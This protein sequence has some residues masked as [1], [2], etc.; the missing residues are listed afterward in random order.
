EHRAHRGVGQLALELGDG[1]HLPFRLCDAPR[2]LV[3]NPARPGVESGTPTG[4]PRHTLDDLELAPA[5]ALRQ[6]GV[7]HGGWRW[8]VC[9]AGAAG[10]V[11][12]GMGP[13]RH[14]PRSW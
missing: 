1:G 9:R 13:A 8:S 2:D 11:A 10:C 5:R 6:D 14:R 12:E 4:K 7:D 3:A